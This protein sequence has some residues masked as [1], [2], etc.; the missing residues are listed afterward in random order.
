M[1][2]FKFNINKDNYQK[3]EIYKQFDILEEYLFSSSINKSRIHKI[4]KIIISIIGV[5]TNLKEVTVYIDLYDKIR[6]HVFQEM[7]MEE[8]KFICQLRELREE[9]KSP[10]L[11][12]IEIMKFND[13]TIQIREKLLNEFNII[14]LNTMKLSG[15]LKISETE[16]LV[17]IPLCQ[18]YSTALKH[19]FSLVRE[20]Q[21][22]TSN[23]IIEIQAKLEPYKSG[24]RKMPGTALKNSA[25]KTVY[26]PPTTL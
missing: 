11:D 3:R 5:K 22:L 23:N 18:N 25:G 10:Y 26:T 14:I 19:G 2:I 16:L 4:N 15:T 21:L 17:E 8:F 24:F 6:C 7:S 12:A 9:I 20:Y 13:G 1:R